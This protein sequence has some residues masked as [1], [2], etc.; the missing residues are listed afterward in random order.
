MRKKSAGGPLIRAA[1]KERMESSA[2]F[3]RQVRLL[4]KASDED[5]LVE[6]MEVV[7]GI[8]TKAE[9]EFFARQFTKALM[10]RKQLREQPPVPVFPLA[11]DKLASGPEPES[12]ME[13]SDEDEDHHVAPVN[14]FPEVIDLT[15]DD[16]SEA[17]LD[18]PINVILSGVSG[19]PPPL[20]PVEDETVPVTDASYECFE[21]V[22]SMQ[23]PFEL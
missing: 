23:F 3:Y 8:K 19:G 12:D 1:R 4:K 21:S 13:S 11:E 22:M 2:K 6:I 14:L 20:E 10:G 16:E 15:L 9:R 5:G 18:M 7:G 17:I